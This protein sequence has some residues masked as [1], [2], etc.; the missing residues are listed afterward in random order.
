MANHHHHRHRTPRYT[1]AAATP[2]AATSDEPSMDD[3]D[4]RSVALSYLGGFEVF[5]LFLLRQR[6]PQV[7]HLRGYPYVL[8]TVALVS[9][10][11]LG[12]Q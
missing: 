12:G 8:L 11:L 2:A 4:G 3:D 5:S 7:I 6:C 1:T 9:F 10:I